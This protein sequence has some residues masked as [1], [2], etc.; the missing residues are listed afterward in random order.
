MALGRKQM[1]LRG[2]VIKNTRWLLGIVIYTGEDTKVA[3]NSRQT[4]N[5]L[6]RL[7]GVVNKALRVVILLM[8]RLILVGCSRNVL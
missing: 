8:A 5:K 1:L 6:S 3:R 7:E 4:P 2:A